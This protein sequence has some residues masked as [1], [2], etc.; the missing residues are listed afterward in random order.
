MKKIDV[1]I[2]SLV[3]LIFPCC[4]QGINHQIA[5]KFE[6]GKPLSELTNKK[7]KEAS[8]LAASVENLD[9][10]WTHNDGGHDAEVY[11]IDKNL[12]I[13]LT[14]TLA[15]IKNR[16]WEDITVGPGPDSTKTY[17]YVGDIGDN[18]AAYS[19]KYIYRFA[20]PV[21]ESAR[22]I[23]ILDFDT[24]IFKLEDSVK[25]TESLFIDHRSKNLYVISK[26]EEPVFLY[27]LKYPQVGGDTLTAY[28]VLSLP[29]TEI[30][31]A[32]CISKHGDILMK[33]YKKIYYWENENGED[34]RTLLKRRPYEI[35]YEEE[36][37]GEAISWAAD[38]SGFY[39]LSEKK[40]KQRSYLYFYSKN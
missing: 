29:F 11:L 18:E 39:T 27:E 13:K 37:Q 1:F 3:G 20:E 14:V 35:P 31:S 8:G 16:D 26:R 22:H 15:G 34:V 7:L 36:P 12:D 25:D 28:K 6:R 19:Y 4:N 2:F 33:N 5:A 38:G 24:I 10:L 9:M 32:D 30:V 23:S 40:K 17:L 21:L